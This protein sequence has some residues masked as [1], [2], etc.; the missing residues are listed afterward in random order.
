MK[1]TATELR[2]ILLRYKKI[3]VVGLST[4]T[5]RS[6]F[7][8]A[9][10]LKAHG[11]DVVG[12]NPGV[13]QAAGCP[14]YATLDQVPQPLEILNVFRASAHVPAV[15]EAVLALAPER[16]PKVLWLTEGVMHPEAERQ[17]EAV[18][19]KVISNCCIMQEHQKLRL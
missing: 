9:E 18:G 2:D 14:V 11:Y 17:A 10:Y 13:V 16:R 15:V 1:L 3:A 6:S 19:I 8:I 7:E 4:R 5:D 12:V